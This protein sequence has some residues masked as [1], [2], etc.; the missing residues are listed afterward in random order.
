MRPCSC[1]YGGRSRDATK[2]RAHSAEA[3]WRRCYWRLGPRDCL[4]D[5]LIRHPQ[6]LCKPVV[7]CIMPSLPH[8]PPFLVPIL[9]LWAA[10]CVFPTERGERFRIDIDSLPEFLE[11]STYGITARV[12]DADGRAVEPVELYMHSFDSR[13]LNIFGGS[14]HRSG[15][16][17]FARALLPGSTQV[18]VGVL[19]F[20]GVPDVT[21]S[22][23]VRP[24]PAA[25]PPGDPEARTVPLRQSVNGRR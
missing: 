10:G 13:I 7:R 14:F 12:L 21:L 16:P 1:G 5:L 25:V 11:D 22:A 24:R 19:T 18:Q 3:G 4:L 23:I 15:E 20:A 9:F 8:P 2:S 6:L 17:A